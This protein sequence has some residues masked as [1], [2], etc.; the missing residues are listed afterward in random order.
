MRLIPASP[1]KNSSVIFDLIHPGPAELA[2]GS[3]MRKAWMEILTQGKTSVL[4]PVSSAS[5]MVV[6]VLD[7]TPDGQS[8]AFTATPAFKSQLCSDL[9]SHGFTE[10]FWWI[11]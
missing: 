1:T 11:N 8:A 7:R 10:V 9:Y 2:A 4:Q 3:L 5:D 6:N